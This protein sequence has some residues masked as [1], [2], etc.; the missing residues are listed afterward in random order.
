MEE[1][2][3]A[4]VHRRWWQGLDVRATARA[5]AQTGLRAHIH[6]IGVDLEDLVHFAHV[7]RDASLKGGQ[8]TLQG[9]T[10]ARGNDRH[11]VARTKAHDFLHLPRT[12]G[13]DD[14]LQMDWEQVHTC[15]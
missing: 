9:R 6:V 15:Y 11:F 13:E 2:V 12:F 7:D 14:G 4:R 1:R 5:R 10:S 3:Q 8:V